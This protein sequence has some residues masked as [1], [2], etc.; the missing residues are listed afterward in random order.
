M[1]RHPSHDRKQKPRVLC[2]D[3]EPRVLA[4]LERQLHRHYEVVTAESAREGILKALREGP[5][6]VVVSDFRMP[7]IDGIS[8][9]AKI[10]EKSPETT[11]VLLT[12]FA[13]GDAA[14]KAVNRGQVFRFLSKPCDREE[15][16]ESLEAAVEH[17]RLV[18][19][20]REL[21]EKTLRGAVRALTD[22][23]SIARPIA[24]SRAERARETALEIAEIL[25]LTDVWP[26]EVAAQLSQIGFITLDESTIEKLHFGEDLDPEEEKKVREAPDLG[27]R[28]LDRIPRLEPVLEILTALRTDFRQGR[29]RGSDENQIPLGARI[30]RVALDFDA[31]ELHGKLGAKAIAIL[32][33]RE[34]AYD[35]DVLEAL[36]RLR[37][38]DAAGREVRELGVRDLEIGMVLAEDVHSRRDSLLLAHGQ[39]ITEP[40]LVRLKGFLENDSIGVR[41]PI[42]VAVPVEAPEPDETEPAV[43]AETPAETAPST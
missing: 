29:V 17:H 23:L 33:G 21:L 32:R 6:A 10:R 42:L 18:V 26:L 28:L 8:M 2:V 39:E 13:D 4:G 15:L 38:W 20:E 41:E 24:F 40:L 14:T 19:A 16:L 3:D 30:L 11:R 37:K 7:Q 5:F 31:L 36:T 12:G 22:V 1:S 35:P 43:D 34:G 25:G 27:L 9:L